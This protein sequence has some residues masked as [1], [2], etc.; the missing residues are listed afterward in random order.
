MAYAVAS[1]ITLVMSL[2]FPYMSFSVQ[3]ISQ[4]ITLYQAV[5]MMNRLDNSLIAAL[6]F[7]AVIFLPA[8]FLISA[9]WFY[10]LTEKRRTHS[11]N[12]SRLAIF[13]LKTLSWVKPWLMV[14]VFLIGV[15][16]S[17]IKIAALADVSMGISFWAFGIYAMLV[18]KTIS[19]VDFD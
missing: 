12:L 18:V 10:S 9:I 7:L 13:I 4:Q 1:L 19:L 14:D 8:Y 2:T 3:G 16:V 17:L 11:P 6:L 5:D 15:L